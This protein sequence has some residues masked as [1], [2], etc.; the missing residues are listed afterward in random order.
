MSWH[1]ATA[2]SA[3]GEENDIGYV[4]RRRYRPVL[5]IAG[6]AIAE[7]GS[8]G[9]SRTRG[10]HWATMDEIRNK[11]GFSKKRKELILGLEEAIRRRQLEDLINAEGKY[12][13]EFDIE[14]NRRNKR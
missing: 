10:V 9:T 7:P 1:E 5:T 8:A 12:I 3:T 6:H 2:T 11:L 14:K 4:Q 13:I